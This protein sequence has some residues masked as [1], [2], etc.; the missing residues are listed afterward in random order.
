MQTTLS[1]LICRK[2]SK[3]LLSQLRPLLIVY[4]KS[5]IN[6]TIHHHSYII[7]MNLN[8][9][10]TFQMHHANTKKRKH[11]KM[12]IRKAL[13]IL[14]LCDNIKFFVCV[15]CFFF[16]LIAEFFIYNAKKK[17]ID[18]TNPNWLQTSSNWNKDKQNVIFVHGY[19]GGDNAPPGQMMRDAFIQSGQFNYFMLDYGPVSR[20]PVI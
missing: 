18:V 4:N 5:L 3:M 6:S 1:F 16:Q 7:R 14:M 17:Q 20:A 12:L 9:I 19:A 13:I 8:K 15:P 2:K 11:Y 10:K